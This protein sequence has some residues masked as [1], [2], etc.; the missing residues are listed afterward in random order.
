MTMAAPYYIIPYLEAFRNLP[1]DA[2]AEERQ[3]LEAL[4]SVNIGDPDVLGDILGRNPE[5]FDDFYGERS[6]QTPDTGDT[7]RIFLSNFGSPGMAGASATVPEE[8]PV[9]PAIDY[10][11]TI[12]APASEPSA[13]A[14][15]TIESESE[16]SPEPAP[17]TESL[18]KILVKNGKYEEAL[19][20]IR[21]LNLKNPEKS[22]Y[23]ADQMR[24]LRKVLISKSKSN[25]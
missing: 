6:G 11:S 13:P 15:A 23:F 16:K 3:R 4:L 5:P 24:F 7:I 8:I 9:V 19:Q 12:L 21:E 22:I 20:I 17:L 18:V 2:P 10:A 1:E 14:Q 25:T